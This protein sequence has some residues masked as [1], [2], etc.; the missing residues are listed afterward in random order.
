MLHDRLPTNSLTGDLE[1]FQV[2]WICDQA[3]GDDL[4]ALHPINK[5]PRRQQ[6]LNFCRRRPQ[7]SEYACLGQVNPALGIP[8]GSRIIDDHFV[9]AGLTHTSVRALD[10]I[11]TIRQST[12]PPSD[13]VPEGPP[14]DTQPSHSTAYRGDYQR[15]RAAVKVCEGV[16]H[17]R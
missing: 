9:I 2:R 1:L 15:D 14:D 8:E 17:G 16:Q 5:E 4:P 7:A 13:A 10:L 12:H 11:S 3:G 6:R